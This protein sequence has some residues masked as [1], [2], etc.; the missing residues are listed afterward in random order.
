MIPEDTVA[1]LMRG[2]ILR[3]FF[4]WS[5]D[6]SDSELGY[7]LCLS[8]DVE[9]IAGIPFYDWGEAGLGLN[10]RGDVLGLSVGGLTLEGGTYGRMGL[11]GERFHATLRTG[12]QDLE[13][14]AG[15]ALFGAPCGKVVGESRC[16]PESSEAT[17]SDSAVGMLGSS[18]PNPEG[19][20]RLY[21]L[22]HLGDFDG[23]IGTGA[24]LG[25][26]EYYQDP[27]LSFIPY[28]GLEVRV[29][30]KLGSET[31]ADIMMEAELSRSEDEVEFSIRGVPV[32]EDGAQTIRSRQGSLRIAIP[33]AEGWSRRT[34]DAIAD[35]EVQSYGH[36][37][38]RRRDRLAAV[39][40][41]TGSVYRTR[42]GRW[43]P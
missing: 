40:R 43:A 33:A 35:F 1:A 38:E 26:V 21:R 19:M 41:R 24:V 6:V 18:V 2:A 29:V 30:R 11:S 15:T 14:I 25:P 12:H 42:T 34:S 5:A 32:P 20:D 28:E 22:T 8:D 27:R 37:A 13:A 17:S 9:V 3:D 31:S 16:E 39:L 36:M 23:T 10:I 7:R 4:G